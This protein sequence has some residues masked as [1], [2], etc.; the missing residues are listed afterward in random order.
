MN[1]SM[2]QQLAELLEKLNRGLDFAT[3]AIPPAI[4][5]MMAYK[6]LSF[7]IF[8]AA[9]VVS[10]LTTAWGFRTLSNGS[11][12][13]EFKE[14]VIILTS[15]GS[16]IMTLIFGMCTIIQ[17][18]VALKIMYFPELWLLDYAHSML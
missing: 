8:L 15:L 5:Q 2:Q 14:L 6:V 3:I 17:G 10:A 7:W 11:I 4:E 13:S 1:E 9:F 12:L 18:V 16:A